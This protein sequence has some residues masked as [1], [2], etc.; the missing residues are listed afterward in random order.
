MVRW[1]CRLIIAA[2]AAAQPAQ[3]ATTTFAASVYNVTGTVVSPAAAIGPSDGLPAMVLRPSTLVLQLSQAASGAATL[4]SGQRL[5]AGTIVQVAVGE[6][7]GGVAT[8]T[9]NL[10]VTG[11]GAL[12]S[13]DFSAA[14]AALSPAGCSLLRVRVAGPAGSAFALDGVSGVAAAPELSAWALMLLGFAF[15]AMRLKQMRP[16]VAHST[17]K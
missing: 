6:V 8:F 15:V 4:I 3:A 5:T 16:A 12:H 13:F 1:I 11:L 7:I 10:Q 14:C 2:L 9:A 17:A